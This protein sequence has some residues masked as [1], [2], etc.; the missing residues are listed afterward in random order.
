M[1]ACARAC[2]VQ[3]ARV[4]CPARP[5]V[6][7]QRAACSGHLVGSRSASFAASVRVSPPLAALCGGPSAPQRCGCPVDDSKPSLHSVRP[8]SSAQ[9]KQ[10]HIWIASL[11]HPR[12]R[13][14]Y[15]QRLIQS[16]P[17]RHRPC[18]HHAHSFDGAGRIDFVLSLS[19]CTMWIMH[20][21]KQL[22]VCHHRKTPTRC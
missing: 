1:L 9:A 5:V 13:K 20:Q 11:I 4:S 22:W 16:L 3:L 8:S 2:L 6:A 21:H 17:N 15:A 14:P 12:N 10:D 19:T 18:H 7:S